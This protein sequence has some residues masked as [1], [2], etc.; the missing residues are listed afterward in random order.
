[1]IEAADEVRLRVVAPAR[2]HH[3]SSSRC[4]ARSPSVALVTS[5]PPQA[6]SQ[7]SVQSEAWR[8]SRRSTRPNVEEPE[9][10]AHVAGSP[11]HAHPKEPPGPVL[12]PRGCPSRRA[13]RVH[14]TPQHLCRLFKECVGLGPIECAQ[15]LR[16]E[17]AAGLLERSE[18]RPRADRR[19]P[20]HLHA[21]PLLA[22]LQAELR[23]GAERVQEGVSRRPRHAS[24][25]THV[26]ASR[27]QA[28]L[29]RSRT[30]QDPKAIAPL[31][32]V[33]VVVVVVVV[34]LALALEDLSRRCR[35]AL[36]RRLA[37]AQGASRPRKAKR[38]QGMA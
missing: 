7:A 32:L 23:H 30:G 18:L 6:P 33:V 3:T 28:L 8:R 2:I 27:T 25:G 17:L 34:V 4:S 22:R 26:P 16:L 14:V 5:L 38:C 29:L 20:R 15:A 10:P 37:A 24:H 9:S 35:R 13:R 31:L 19:P 21:V 1:M 11:K 36:G 12:H